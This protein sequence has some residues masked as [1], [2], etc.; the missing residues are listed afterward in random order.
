MNIEEQRKALKTVLDQL[1]DEQVRAGLQA[2]FDVLVRQRGA[3]ADKAPIEAKI[4]QLAARAQ[5]A[6]GAQQGGGEED[7]ATGPFLTNAGFGLVVGI[8]ILSFG[9][10]FYY[11]WE[12]GGEN[13]TSPESIR[14]LLVLTL[15]IAMLGFGG[16][17]M[18]RAL[19]APY[20]GAQLQERFRLGREVFLVFSGIFGTII[21]FYF[22][23]EDDERGGAPTV[24]IAFENGR[25]TAA[26]A[27]GVEPFLGIF[28]PRDQTGGRVMDA[29]D[30]VLSYAVEGGA[31]PDGATVVVVDG[32][33]HRADGIVD[34]DDESAPADANAA[35][36]NNST[37]AANVNQGQ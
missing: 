6:L 19:F 12:I 10:V 32:R 5:Q 28:T 21:G 16:L 29:D 17:L 22:G 30:R 4:E 33:G 8:V 3:A 13:F 37:D 36:A 2:E 14:P 27:E 35:A 26:V 24:A 20:Q 11:F 7:A 31:C 34:C 25:V 1:Q 23:A 18:V 9:F 15:I